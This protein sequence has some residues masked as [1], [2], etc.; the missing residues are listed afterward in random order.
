[1]TYGGGG[2]AHG[3]RPRRSGRLAREQDGGERLGARRRAAHR[4]ERC[5]LD[6]AQAAADDVQYRLGWGDV[7]AGSPRSP[8]LPRRHGDCD[9]R[10]R[11]GDACAPPQRRAPLQ[12]QSGSPTHVDD[13]LVDGDRR[14]RDAGRSRGRCRPGTYR[15]RCAPGHGLVAGL[16]APFTVAVRRAVLLLVAFAA[17]ALSATAA[18]FPNTEPLA[19]KQWYLTQDKAWDF[20]ADGAAA[21]TPVKVAVIDSGIDGAHPDLA[22]PSRR[23]RSRS[24]AARRI[25][26]EQRPR[27]V[28]RGRDRGEPFERDR[29]RRARVQR[30]AADRKGR[31]ARRRG[32]APGRGRG[33]PLG[34]RRGRDA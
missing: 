13:A 21:L 19:A 23:W 1:M 20:W 34:G 18:A 11:T 15:V 31:D 9:H 5:V 4:R 16:S 12:L 28:R 30:P 29:H 8:S 17:L 25:T 7:R 26:D 2:V 32:L 14:E 3:L 22:G 6:R 27:H 33:D 10:R 24:S